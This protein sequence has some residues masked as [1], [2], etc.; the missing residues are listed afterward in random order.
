MKYFLCIFSFNPF[1][2]TRVCI[3]IFNLRDE[4]GAAQRYEETLPQI[5]SIVGSR[6]KTAIHIW[7]QDFAP[8]YPVVNTLF[9]PFNLENQGQEKWKQSFNYNLPKTLLGI[10]TSAL[11]LLPFPS[12]W[13]TRGFSFTYSW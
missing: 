13:I 10:S 6:A 2:H 11:K 3:I 5:L 12:T 1:L 9:L 8:Y 7:L 4:D